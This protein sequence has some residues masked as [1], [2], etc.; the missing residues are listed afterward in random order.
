MAI[1]DAGLNKDDIDVVIPTGSQFSNQFSNELATARLVEEL[2]LSNVKRSF[3]V[4]SGRTSSS[5]ALRVAGAVVEAGEAGTELLG[6]TDKLGTGASGKG[7][8]A[9]LST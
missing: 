5:N 3:Q 8:L 7:G 9:P 6:P 4:F 2:G 1:L